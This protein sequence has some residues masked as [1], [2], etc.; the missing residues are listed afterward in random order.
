VLTI[1]VGLDNK[2]LYEGC[3]VSEAGGRLVLVTPPA[4]AANIIGRNAAKLVDAVPSG[5]R[6]AVT[7]TG[8]MAVWAYLVVFHVICHQFA[9]VWYNDGRGGVVLIAKH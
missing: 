8:A 9:E 2:E 4:E 3:E 5:E 7:L 6:D 1:N